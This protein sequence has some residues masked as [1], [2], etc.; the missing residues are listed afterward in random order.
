MTA[1]AITRDQIDAFANTDLAA[2]ATGLAQAGGNLG[3]LRGLTDADLERIYTLAYQLAGRAQWHQAE[4][5][6][7][8]LCFYQHRAARGWRGRAAVSL[9]VLLSASGGPRLAWPGAVPT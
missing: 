5:L 1:D 2:F 8:C 9:S 7:R 4:P 6:F 3:A